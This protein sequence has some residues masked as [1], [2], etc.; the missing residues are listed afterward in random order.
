MIATSASVETQPPPPS[1]I[2]L[3]EPWEKII[4]LLS[5]VLVT[6]IIFVPVRALTAP[7]GISAVLLQ[8]KHDTPTVMALTCAGNDITTNTSKANTDDDKQ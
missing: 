8:A 6:F 3:M 1:V 4:L 2:R 5:V 7:G